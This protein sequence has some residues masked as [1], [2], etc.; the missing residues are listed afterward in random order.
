MA[1][2]HVRLVVDR[3]LEHRGWSIYHL[4]QRSG[5][6]YTTCYRL[7]RRPPSRIEMATL[8]ALCETLECG[9]GDLLVYE[10]PESR[11]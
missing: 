10:P 7:T 4:A 5:L 6:P 8:A 1:R 9:P 3:V 11:E 2:G